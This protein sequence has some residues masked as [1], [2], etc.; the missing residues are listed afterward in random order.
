M[1]QVLAYG[2][3]NAAGAALIDTPAISDPSFV[4]QNNHWLFY[5]NY[6]LDAVFLNGVSLTAAQL[7]TPTLNSLN[8]PQVYPPN[9]SLAPPSNPQVMDLRQYPLQLPM[10]AQ[11]A[12]QLS[13]NLAMGNEWEFLLLFIAPFGQ[14]RGLPSPA[15]PYGAMGRIR[16]L[17]TVTVALTAGVWSPVTPIAIPNLIMQGT[18]CVTGIELI[19]AHGVAGRMTFPRPPINGTRV[20]R[21]GFLTN[22]AYGNIPLMKGS[23]WMGPFGYFDT[24]EFPQLEILAGTTTNSATYTGYIDMVYMGMSLLGQSGAPSTV[25]TQYTPNQTQL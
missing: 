8:I 23:S 4:T 24:T 19:C 18:W 13:N 5:E 20:L 3:N 11:I 14:P 22:A 6:E 16:A 17:F 10:N 12:A 15:A 7:F 1:F 21:P 2:A 25:G 9:L